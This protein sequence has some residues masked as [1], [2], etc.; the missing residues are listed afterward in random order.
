[1][2][3]SVRTYKKDYKKE[4]HTQWFLVNVSKIA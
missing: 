3:S 1:M 4:K 2:I